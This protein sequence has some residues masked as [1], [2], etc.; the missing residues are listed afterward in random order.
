MTTPKI[1]SLWVYERIIDQGPGYRI[2]FGRDGLDI[3][4][5]LVGGSKKGQQKDIDS[6]W[7]LI[8]FLSV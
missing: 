2:Y 8:D 4:I 5:L 7:R 6:R 1:H 3:V